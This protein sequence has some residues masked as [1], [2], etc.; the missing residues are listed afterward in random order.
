MLLDQWAVRWNIPYDALMD[1]RNSVLNLDPPPAA[2][3]QGQSEA[4]VQSNVRLEASQLNGR[5]WRNNVGALK[6][7][8]GIPVRYGLANDSERVNKVLKSSDLIGLKPIRITQA[9]VGKL[10]G[11]FWARE[12]KEGGWRFTGTER[13]VAQLNFIKLVN[14]LGGDAA[15]A[16]GTGTL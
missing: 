8:R 1:L 11:Q 13:E 4:A 9:H 14:V 12:C 6:D 16:S 10:I 5:L 2:F 15:F 3:V 7:S